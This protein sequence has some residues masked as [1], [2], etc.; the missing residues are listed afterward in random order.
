MVIPWTYGFK[1]IKSIVKITLTAAQPRTSW[2]EYAP[3]EYGFYANVNQHKDHPRWSQATEQRIGEPG[4]GPTLMFNGYEQQ[5]R[6]LYAGMDL[7]SHSD[8]ING[9]ERLG[10]PLHQI[11]HLGQRSGAGGVADVGCTGSSI[12][13]E[14]SK[15][16]HFVSTYQAMDKMFLDF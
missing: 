13:S 14:P 10:H 5:V 15:F 9:H 11:S 4:R 16:C 1:R 7:E 6:H 2:S 12:G 3:I 8:P